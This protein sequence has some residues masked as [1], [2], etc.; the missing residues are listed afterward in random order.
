MTG[1]VPV[2]DGHND[3][4]SRLWRA[5]AADRDRIWLEGDGSG[6]LDLPRMRRGGFAGGLFAI[7][8]PSPETGTDIDALMRDPPFDLP[9]PDPVGTDTAQPAA[10]AMAG[11]LMRM[12][13]VSEG[14]L[15]LCRSAAE[16]RACLDAD[17]I[18][19]VLHMEGAEAIGPDLDALHVLHAA[20]LRS[21]G[22]VWSRPTI[23]GHGVPFRFP[24]DPDTGPGLTA[25]GR[26]L[27]RAC[28]ALR[29]VIDLS[30][31]NAAGFDDVAAV[32]TAPLVASHS[33]AHAIC[34]ASRNLTDRQLAMIRERAGLVGL[35]FAAAFLRPDGRRAVDTGW[36]PAL[37][38]LDHLIAHLGEDHVG[39]GSDFDGATIPGCIGDVTGLPAFEATLRAHGFDTPLLA[40]LLHGNW[41]R[42]L[43]RVW[44]A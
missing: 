36:D 38:H 37:R 3:L 14:V 10:L 8:V 21:L 39:I 25:L 28:D 22:P 5:G 11:I 41:L 15:R 13:R 40:K 35:N 1:P 43:E 30:H 29:I 12:E 33:N 19:A 34:P 9:L 27:V 23:F 16:I 4:L 18:A 31:L 17:V 20:G 24:G 7:W 6:H 44:G 32:S 2:F 26:D 42:L